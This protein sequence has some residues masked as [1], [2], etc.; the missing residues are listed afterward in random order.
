MATGILQPGTEENCHE[1]RRRTLL[2]VG[3]RLSLS[4]LDQSTDKIYSHLLLPFTNVYCFFS[5]N[6]SGFRQIARHL[7]V[8]LQTAHLSTLSRNT[9][10]R[11]VIVTKKILPG[12]EEEKEAKKAFLLLLGEEMTSDLYEQIPDIYVVA[13]LPISRVSPQA[14]YRPLGECLLNVSDDVQRNRE[15][16]RTLFSTTHFT[17]LF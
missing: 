10:P 15:E 11:V 1:T 5:A 13:L 14:R 12:A 17:T 6:V 4:T 8:W 16:T 3:G 7:A 9:Y 2:R